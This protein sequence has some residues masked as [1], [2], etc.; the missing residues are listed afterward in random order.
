MTD[1]QEGSQAEYVCDEGFGLVGEQYRVCLETG[2]WSGTEPQC[3]GILTILA[4]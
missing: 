1:N 2:K 3:K 4:H